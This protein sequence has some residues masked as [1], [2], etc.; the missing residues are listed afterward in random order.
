MA[1]KLSYDKLWIKLIEE[2]RTKQEL[3][4]EAG[5]SCG[6]L[7]KMNRGEPVKIE[8]LLKICEVLG[9]DIGDICSAVPVEQ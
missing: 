6:T 3:R 7:T 2:K 8:I 5:F 1:L 9:C 4:N